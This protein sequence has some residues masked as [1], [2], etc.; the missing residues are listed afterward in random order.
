MSG[1]TMYQ[2]TEVQMTELANQ[3]KEQIVFALAGEGLLK[4]DPE[5]VAREYV[6][7]LHQRGFFG[8]MYDKFRGTD[9]DGTFFAVLKTVQYGASSGG[10]KPKKS[11]KTK[12]THLT[13]VPMPGKKED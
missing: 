12:A 1:F 9:K 10:S 13:A 11:E 3:A 7:V 2:Y 4:G 8:K 5:D 6:I